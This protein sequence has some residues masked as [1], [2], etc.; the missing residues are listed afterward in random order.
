M[1]HSAPR[2]LFVYGTLLDAHSNEFGKLLDSRSRAIRPARL[3]AR[4]YDVGSYPAAILSSNAEDVVHGLVYHLPDDPE[5]L[6]II[7]AYEG[8][9]P[10]NPQQS[11]YRRQE[12]TVEIASTEARAWAYLYNRPSEGLKHIPSGSYREHLAS[13]R[14][15]LQPEDVQ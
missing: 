1:S 8:W 13:V 4:L 9:Y 6:E 2:Y 14:G 10:E 3:R 12:V 7:D 15:A 11:E 5:L